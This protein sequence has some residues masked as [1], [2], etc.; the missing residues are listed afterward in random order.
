[1][2]AFLALSVIFGG[3]FVRL[4]WLQGVDPND[5]AVQAAN[6]RTLA[7]TLPAVRGP[8]LDA[9]GV[10]LATTVDA[11]DVIVDQTQMSNPAAAALQLAGPLD[12]DPAVLQAEMTGGSAY[13][14][15]AR[16][17]EGPVWST[18]R[19]MGIKGIYS[20]PSADRAYPAGAVA[21]NIIGFIGNNGAE[22]ADEWIGGQ[23]GLE[24]SYEEL[25][26]GVPGS[27]RYER[28]SA[29]RAIPLARQSRVDPVP[30]SGL[31]LTIDRDIQWMVERALAA[32]VAE[33]KAANGSAIV[34]DPTTGDILALA[35]VPHVNPENPGATKP[36]DRITRSV[37]APY[38]PGSVQKVI[39]MAA[40]LDSGAAEPDDVFTVPDSI[41]REGADRDLGDF[42]THEDWQITL[43][44]I[45]AKSSNV[46][47]LLA[48]EEMDKSE[49]RDYLVRFGYGSKPG[50]GMPHESAGQMAEEWSDLQ[51]DTISYGQGIST[52]IVHLAAA[53]GAL[54]ND[55]LRMPPR[56]VEAVVGSDGAER[57]LPHAE[58]VQVVS[59]QTARQVTRM[60]EAVV[61][62]GGTASN[63]VVDGYRIA[64]KTGTAQRLD[65]NGYPVGR[66]ASFAGFAPAD[67]PQLVVVV[68][69]HDPPL[70]ASGGG[71]AGPVFA[72]I[73]KFA[74]PRLGIAPTGT[75]APKVPLF[76]DELRAAN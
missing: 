24:E 29:G 9:N 3:F 33:S 26:A 25:L 45:L 44:G 46:G 15:I 37:S 23:S 32:K 1:T 76:A 2:A 74:L 63:V 48:A 31:R 53:Y 34:Y 36:G 30:G 62:E 19:A 75:P 13:E 68:S 69:L 70:G 35:D 73:M 67:D 50:I 58:P 56:L 55:G 61:G 7:I 4:V 57:A 66:T 42:A 38:E 12:R 28:D 21:G 60:M 54:A 11:V 49:L 16:A 22:G 59:A 64:G 40:V 6:A 27:L 71:T 10:P 18:I 52:T 51:R 65:I 20:E 39:T 41:A 14:P 5:W 47:T 17:V 72:D 8:I 43:S